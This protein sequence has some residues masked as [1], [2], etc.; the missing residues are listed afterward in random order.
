MSQHNATVIGVVVPMFNAEKTIL[1][2]LTSICQQSHQALDIIVVDDGSTD[3]SA[4][5]VAAYAEQDRRIRFF[6]QPNAGVAHARNSGAA[7]TDAEFLAF[8]DADDL[9]AP[10]KIALQLRVLQEGGSS[11]GLAYCWFAEIDED[12]R[13]FSFKQPD[14]DGRVLQRMCRNNFVGNGSSMLVRRSAF[15]R[16]GQFDP[17]LRARNA[18]GC[19]DLLMCLRIAEN[20]EFRVVP[21]YLV[22]YR[23]TSCNM[24]S[25]V[26]QMFRSYQIVLAEFHEKYPQFGSDL[27]AHLL[28]TINALAV[29]ALLQGRPSA[30]WYLSKKLFVLEPR[31]AISRLPHTVD[32]CCRGLVPRWIKVRVKRMRNA[33]S[34]PLYDKIYLER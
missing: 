31:T 29:R 21:Q 27:N 20:Y 17:S 18:Q 22:G 25:D 5:I 14:A 26:M 33:E 8:V 13:I 1:P 2:T 23:R 12:G 4:S 15:E 30:A 24:S 32:V 10:S 16:A 34:R 7:A 9:W 3:R 6:R 11:V 28:D 19:E